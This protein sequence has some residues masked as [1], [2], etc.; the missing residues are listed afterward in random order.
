MKK[1]K[2]MTYQEL[3]HGFKNKGY[4]LIN[5]G[6]VREN[7][8]YPLNKIIVNPRYK[9]TLLITSGFHGEEFNGPI[10]LLEIFDE[11]ATYAKKMRVRLVVYPCVNPSGFDLHQR[12][13]ASGEKQN[14]DFLRYVIEDGKVVSILKKDE[15]F[16]EIKAV[17][18]PAKEVRL[19][20]ID[21]F[22]SFLG[23]PAGVLDIHQQKGNLKTGE[24]YAYIF[25]LRATYRRIMKKLGR[26]AKV[27]KNDPAMNFDKGRKVLYRIDEDG[28]IVLHDGTLTDMFY[29]LGSKFVVT[30]E[31]KT[32]L[33]LEQVSQINLI[34]IKELIKLIAKE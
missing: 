21:M 20:K 31:T 33:P 16:T 25:N 19:L 9:K 18:S 32:T 26:V 24:F 29:R 5:Y 15:P 8:K 12:Y 4:A 27:A 7:Q 22:S 1:K 30:A 2:R 34:W 13:N 17:N 6:T 23:A 14:N 11:V 28:L 3:M 10:S